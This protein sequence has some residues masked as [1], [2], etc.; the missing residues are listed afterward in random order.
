MESD[1][2]CPE[3]REILTRAVQKT[4]EN[5]QYFKKL[6]KMKSG[7]VDT[8]MFRLHTEVFEEIDCLKCSNC[9]RGT[10]PLLRERDISRL[11]RTLRMKPGQF[12]SQY[13]RMDEEGDYVFQSMPCPFILE[14]NC[15]M[16][17]EDRPGACRDYPHS[18]C[19]SFKKY[20]SQMLANTKICPA[21][22]LLFEKMKKVIPL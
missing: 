12:T 1:K 21:L 15:C 2:T 13:L 18:D 10:G 6:K 4:K 19:I 9:C 7:E 20:S 11:S 8:L 5:R 17:Y 16:V 3:Y 14:D 22:F